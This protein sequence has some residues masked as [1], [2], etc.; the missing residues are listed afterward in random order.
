MT[1][2]YPA[3]L[4]AALHDGVPGDVDFYRRVA[5]GAGSVLELG[6][7]EGRVSRALA[8]DGREVVGVDLDE[9]LVALATAAGGGPTYHHGD[10]RRLALG[11]TFDRVIAPFGTAYCMLTEAD[12][13]AMLLR[14]R[15]HLAPEGLLVFDGYAA[16]AFHAESTN[17]GVDEEG[18]LRTVE[19]DGRVW[20]VHEHSH[21]RRD[22]QRIDAHYR[23]VPRDGGDAVRATIRQRYLLADQVEPLLA[24]AGL[25][26][27]VLHGGFDQHVFDEESERLIVT[28]RRA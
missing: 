12:L 1:T 17:D 2:P 18:F 16:D 4:H 5:A 25:A 27:V 23:H 26:L 7:G 24:R 19:A 14:A 10:V 9:G 21:W 8:A 22:D 6:C 13:E 3:S 28:A 20:D 15:A 11:R